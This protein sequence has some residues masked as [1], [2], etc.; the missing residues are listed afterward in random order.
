MSEL[1]VR[2]AKA[3]LSSCTGIVQRA[4][5]LRRSKRNAASFPLGGTAIAI[6]ATLA[7]P[8]Q[9]HRWAQAAAAQR[10][11][12][13]GSASRNLFRSMPGPDGRLAFQSFPLCSIRQLQVLLLEFEQ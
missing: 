8:L 11:G 7:P 4:H 10:K 2:R 9:E 1:G 5:T 6:W 3:A 13:A 12:N